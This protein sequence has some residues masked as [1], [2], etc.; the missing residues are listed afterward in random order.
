MSPSQCYCTYLSPSFDYLDPAQIANEAVVLI[1]LKSDRSLAILIFPSIFP[2]WC[3]CMAMR[4]VSSR[5]QFILI[6]FLGLLR[7]IYLRGPIIPSLFRSHSWFSHCFKL[8]LGLCLLLIILHLILIS[9]SQKILLLT[10]ILNVR[11]YI[12]SLMPRR[13]LLLPPQAPSVTSC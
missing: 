2:S 3:L 13:D 6:L 12:C 1:M 11:S 8:Q 5:N 10:Y 7:S 4:L 9:P